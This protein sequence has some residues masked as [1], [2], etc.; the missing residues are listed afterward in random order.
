M[1]IIIQNSIIDKLVSEFSNNPIFN[2]AIQ[3]II[4]R[5]STGSL[6]VVDEFEPDEML[7]FIQMS[8]L[9]LDNKT[10]VGFERFLGI[11]MNPKKI[12]VQLPQDIV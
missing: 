8:S 6:T 9:L 7:H 3:H 11:L 12:K 2:Q 1:R 4:S 5:K 10:F